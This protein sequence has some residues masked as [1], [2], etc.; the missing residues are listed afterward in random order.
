MFGYVRA[1]KPEMKFSEFDTYKAVYCSLCKVL[2]KN[3]GMLAQY[4]LSYDFTFLSMLLLSLEPECCGYAQMRCRYNPLKK[5]MR[6]KKQSDALDFSAAA[7][8]ISSYYKI[9][10]NIF[11]TKF[12]KRFLYKI[13]QLF[14]R[15]HYKK[16]VKAY[17]EID[18]ICNQMMTSQSKIEAELCDSLDKAAEPTAIF[19][20]ELFD[21][22]CTVN[23]QS[24][25]MSRIG[26]CAGKMIYLLD[27]LDDLE[28]DNKSGNYNPFNLKYNNLELTE[29]K[30]NA[31]KLINVCLTEM[32]ATYELLTLK[33]YKTILNN[34]IYFGMPKVIENLKKYGT[35][36]HKEENI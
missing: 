6:L 3:Y 10:D 15:R 16:A 31:V 19:L 2:G 23:S 9:K 33:R 25:V 17:P 13:L 20:Q 32:A 28:Y 26:Y 30:E 22:G 11:D 18:R 1:Y 29:I 24:R 36:E 5:C 35:I 12:F 4:T 14:Y 8:V 34:I 27:A 21:L 7:L